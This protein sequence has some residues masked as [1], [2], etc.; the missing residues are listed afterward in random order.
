MRPLDG[1]FRPHDEVDEVRWLPLAGAAEALTHE[2]DRAV[3][4]ALRGAVG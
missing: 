4:A 1:D 3:L 2:R